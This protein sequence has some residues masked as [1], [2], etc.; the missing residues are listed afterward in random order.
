ME[1]YS[2]KV[3]KLHLAEIEI[4]KEIDKIRG[5]YMDWP[6]SIANIF[7][8]SYPRIGILS[9]NDLVQEG[10]AAFFKAWEKLDQDLLNKQPDDAHRIAIITNYMKT[11]IKN[12]IR[13]A[14]ANDR[15]TIRIPENQYNKK[16][17]LQKQDIFLTQTFSSFFESHLLDI[18]DEPYEYEQEKINEILNTHMGNNL[19]SVERQVV[20]M[21]FGIDQAYDTK[22]SFKAVAEWFGKSEAWVRKIKVDALKK[23]REPQNKEILLK[24]LT[25]ADIWRTGA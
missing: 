21:C 17:P 12:T 15:D 16:D 13:R 20:S 3:Y 25:D 14:I 9:L 10:N 24:N 2:H 8:R 23:L 4:Y 22:K 7:E 19:T 11:S 5:P 18:P 6:K 1:F